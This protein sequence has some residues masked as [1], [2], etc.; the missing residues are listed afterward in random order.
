MKLMVFL[1]IACLLACNLND[2]TLV[3]GSLQNHKGKKVYFEICGQDTTIGVTLDSTGSFEANLPLKEAGYV[4]LANGKAVF[5][6]YL[7]PGKEVQVK[8]NVEKVQN[9]DYSA[10]ELI[11]GDNPETRMMVEYYQKQWFPST[12]EMFVL[13]PVQFKQMVDSIVRFNDAVISNF[14]KKTPCDPE[15]E[16]LFRIQVKV[17]LA[18][19]YFYYPMYHSLLNREDQ[20][21]MPENFNIFDEMLPKN[22]I[23]I[24]RKIYRY[25]IYEVSYWN[26]L[27]V[28][29][30]EN[31]MSKPGQFVNTYI[32][33]L[34]KLGLHQH[35]RD[36]VGNNFV[37][38]YYKEL[39]RDAVQV[40]RNRYKEVVSNPVCQE[41]IEEAFQLLD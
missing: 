13:P 40:M 9:G 20:S 29:K 3:K 17:P 28:G 14:V 6:L 25:K 36:D 10:V 30:L 39:P 41:K 15:F 18:A 11:K 26:N 33:E 24:Y 8:V 38:Q 35:I 2:K 27:L 16:R 22:D 7:L 5:P 19:S 23:D 1:W 37:M 32:D 12:Q 34:N 21:E 4:R 31:L